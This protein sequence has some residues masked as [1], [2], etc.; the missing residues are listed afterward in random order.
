MQNDDDRY[1]RQAADAQDHADRALTERVRA[2]WLRLAAGWLS[3][4]RPRQRTAQDDFNDRLKAE[5]T[6]QDVSRNSQ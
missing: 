4:L 1:R 6:R 5:G 2:A 3:L